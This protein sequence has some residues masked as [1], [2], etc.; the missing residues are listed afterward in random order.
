MKLKSKYTAIAGFVFLAACG[1][2]ALDLKNISSLGAGFVSMFAAAPNSEP[3][4]AQS[5]NIAA[6][7][8]TTDP[9]NP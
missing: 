1:S 6:I 3:V 9:F 8:F 2:S 5:V 7:S 4:D